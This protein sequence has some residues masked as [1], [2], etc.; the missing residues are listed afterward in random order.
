M[1]CHNECETFTF[2][3]TISVFL[4]TYTVYLVFHQ[5]AN[6]ITIHRLGNHLSRLPYQFIE[7]SKFIRLIK[8]FKKQKN[9]SNC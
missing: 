7:E 3:L 6:F 1:W 2:N 8:L 4:N 5:I 9:L